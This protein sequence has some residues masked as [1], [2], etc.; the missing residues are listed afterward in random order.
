MISP[1]QTDCAII[2]LYGFGVCI[3]F[4]AVT[5]FFQAT[6]TFKSLH[7]EYL[8]I[9]HTDYYRTNDS[10]RR[11]LGISLFDGLNITKNRNGKPP[12]VLS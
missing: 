11:R 7:P 12:N 5:L 6:D 2:I 10:L 4:F 9:T 8:V 1:P 3:Y